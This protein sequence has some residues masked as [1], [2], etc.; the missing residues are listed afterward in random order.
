MT[1]IVKRFTRRDVVLTMMLALLAAL[2]AP[3]Q[4]PIPIATLDDLNKIGR[5]TGY[6]LNGYYL[7]TADIDASP[8]ASWNGGAGFEPIGNDTT[9]FTGTFDGNGHAIHGLTIN[10][11]SG[12][13]AGLFGYIGSAGIVRN[14]RLEGGSVSLVTAVSQAYA[15]ALAGYSRG[16]IQDC[17]SSCGVNLSNTGYSYAGALVGQTG[18]GSLANC[19]ATGTVSASSSSSSSSY[20]YAGGL[21]GSNSATLTTCYAT[22]TVSASSS[23][24]SSAYTYAGGL[25]GSNSAALTGCSA[26]GDVSASSSS[27]DYRYAYTYAGGLVGSN[28]AALTTCSAT[29]NVSA[30]S[31]SSSYY[32]YTYAGGLVGDNTGNVSRS[33][34][35]GAITAGHTTAR[36]DGYAGG[37]IGRSG[38]SALVSQSYASGPVIARGSTSYAGGCVGYLSGSSSKITD[39]YALGAVSSI[40]PASRAGGLLGYS[41]GTV[42]SS[43][44]AGPVGEGIY[45]G[46]LV[47]Q[48]TGT[49]TNGYWDTD[50]TGWT[51]SAGGTGKDTAAMR[52][53]ATFDQWN[54][55]AVW[56]IRE[57][58]TYPYLRWQA[59]TVTVPDLAGLSRDEAE[60]AL[61]A[62]WLGRGTVTERCD[63]FQPAGAVAGQFPTAGASVA[64]G[65]PVDLVVST[66]PCDTVVP[67][68]VGRDQST[69]EVLLTSAGLVV[70][71]VSSQCSASIP[72]GQVISQLPAAG[73][74]TASGQAVSLVVSAGTPVIPSLV[75]LSEADARAA[76]TAV[77]G[78]FVGSV[79]SQ[80]SDTIAPGT[81]LSQ[82]PA[83]G[84]ASCGTPVGLVIASG[85]CPVP[86]P[87][88]VGQAQDAAAAALT[89]ARLSVGIVT[90][91]CSSSVP[92]GHVII[93]D[94]AAGASVAPGTPVNL[95]VSN[96][97]P[98]PVS[99]PNVVGQAQGTASS[100]LVNAG[101]AVGAI[102]QQC[103]NSVAAGRVI[104][105]NPAAGASV[106]PGTAV[107]LVVSSGPC[108][109]SVPNVV[110]QAQS[111]A[112]ST[113]VN[114]GL[115][116]G[117]VTQQCSNT[118]AAGRVISQD[119]AAGASV[120]PGTAVNL[121]VSSGPCSVSVPNVVG[122]AQ[123]TASSTLVNAGLAVGTVTQ[124]CSNT[125][126][127]GRVISQ[128][129]AAGA[130]VAPGTA[131]SLVVSTGVPCGVTVPN[132]VGVSRTDALNTLG[133]LGLTA[134]T[135]TY[136]CSNVTAQD[137][138]I[139][140]MPAQ[141][142]L[143]Q[144]GTAVSMLVST[145]A[146]PPGTAT[147]PQVVGLQ[148]TTARDALLAAGLVVGIITRSCSNT[149]ERGVVMSQGT[150]AG[151]GVPQ[152]TAVNLAISAGPCSITVP[153]VR[154][155]TRD[156]AVA[157]LTGAALATGRE[158]TRC[159]DTVPAGRVISQNPSSSAIVGPDT[160]VD[161]VISLGPCRVTVPS[162]TGMTEQGAWNTLTAAGLARGNTTRA[163][164][165]NVPRDQVFSQSLQPGTVVDR[166]TSISLTV[167]NGPCSV[168]MPSLVGLTEIAARTAITEANLAVGM[169]TLRCDDT[170]PTNV[171]L[172]QNVA[173]GTVVQAG[174]FVN[175]V[176]S[177]G[178]CQVPDVRNTAEAVARATLTNARFT[179]GNVA[180]Q[181][182]N[183]VAQGR[184][185]SQNPVAGTV[186]PAGT[187]VSLVVS[188][189]PCPVI[190]PALAGKTRTEAET[191]IRAAGLA[192]GNVTSSCSN[193]VPV[194]R[195]ISQSPAA[196]TE[197]SPGTAID[198]VISTGPCP[199]TIPAVTGLVQTDAEAQITTA[200][201]TVGSVTRQCSDTV[202]A[203]QV[204][205]QN[206]AAGASVAPGSAVNLV[207]SSG[208]CSVSVPGVVGLTQAAA[209]T[210][211]TAAGLTIGTVSQ[212][213][214]DTVPAG[215]VISQN[216]AAGA[217]VSAGSAVNLVV[218]SGPCVNTGG[219]GT[220]DTGQQPPPANVPW[221]TQSPS[222]RVIMN[223]LYD[224]FS[225]VDRNGD[226]ALSPDEVLAT[227][228][229]TSQTA[230]ANLDLNGDSQITR[231]ELESYLGIG[232]PFGCVRRLFVKRLAPSAMSDLLLAGL[233][234]GILVA[235]SGRRG[236]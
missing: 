174:T 91:Q 105:Q 43:Y 205:S 66:G 147:V 104:S 107:N 185:I 230:F 143:V 42:T 120:A 77:A 176:V 5:A 55:D 173:P 121:V 142:A 196:G 214:G 48:G 226:G 136:A 112:S 53:R 59:E 35:S 9:P 234:L 22:G 72:A 231:A 180:Y 128:N 12:A 54:F 44:A 217:P 100:T 158:D 140:Q 130:S 138:V 28:G 93:Q 102:T 41:E 169:V 45:T 32:A 36:H 8:T 17:A 60:S 19:S 10:R 220:G 87:S 75:G 227:L 152:G 23:S 224:G 114:A 182:S 228:A 236:T 183:T 74:V 67:D 82:N 101:L 113:L 20:T 61:R 51:W 177:S 126:A 1:H 178:P 27:S 172:S 187:P 149:T 14:L 162:V 70:G 123:S 57:G 116:V 4:T 164:N 175:I 2:A 131:V 122:Q 190:A 157:T 154:G 129:P 119:P 209:T 222:D 34:A 88:V 110:G 37:L 167:S 89:A 117:T 194:T 168:S 191:A 111:T 78:L 181:C 213:C 85:P 125:V 26:T 68:V 161:L 202:P 145:G 198:L 206:P 195:V 115:A 156:A 84:P 199:V 65:A 201:L 33:R 197:V 141:G 40:G 153:D 210:S 50:T 6:P 163:C 179:V 221:G 150:P 39:C 99:V 151:T 13:Y 95:V 186:L 127:A 21:V 58:A 225:S 132:I 137:Y 200:G 79:R 211:L 203:G 184:V 171:V 96:G 31:S 218:A 73:T 11:T 155:L 219:S 94:P 144:P 108:P 139:S 135:I 76:I 63:F 133:S 47:A 25:V 46:G 52:A 212:Q 207:I 49:V 146:C 124:Q 216:P 92:A 62:A 29:G 166:G 106:A 80:C 188:S 98:C 192:V 118:V 90:Q 38:G 109:V 103:S 208:P 81:V 83:P 160:P 56:T 30:S 223:A 189:G 235:A 15:G 232:G 71:T 193:A 170:V 159:D 86:V 229:S 7:L 233:G 165:D 134:G 215:Q 3:A 69:A 64:L 97:T 24:Y 16:S 148:E 18:G 204:I